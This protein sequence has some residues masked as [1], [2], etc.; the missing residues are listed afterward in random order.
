MTIQAWGANRVW[1]LANMRECRAFERALRAP[2]VAQEEKLRGYLRRNAG[3]A[4]AREHGLTERTTL[5][6][7]RGRV[8]VRS[9]AEL[10]GYVDRIG[11]GEAGVLT[12]ERVEMFTP[13]S[14]ST[15]GAGSVKLIPRTASLRGE[16][17]AALAPWVNGMFAERPGV[18][19]GPAYWSVSPV[20]PAEKRL[21]GV[22]PVGF[23][24][25]DEY[26]SWVGRKIARAVKAIPGGTEGGGGVARMRSAA[27]WRYA[28]L[29]MLLRTRSLAM[30]S[31]W[32][33]S[34]LEL[35]LE[36]MPGWWERLCADVAAGSATLPEESGVDRALAPRARG[37]AARAAELRG[38]G[39]RDV[40]G[41]WPGLEL[42]SC[43]ADGAAA[44]H[45]RAL[46]D[47]LGGVAVV[48]KGLLATEA[49]V[50]IPW[51]GMHPVAVRS[52]FVEL[53]DE[54][55]C[56]RSLHEARPGEAYVPVV[57]TGGGLWR[58]RLGDR[59]VVD[60]FVERT[61]SLRFVGRVDSVSDLRGEKLSDAFV[62]ASLAECEVKLGVRARFS[63]LGGDADG[64][65][66]IWFVDAGDGGAALE[67]AEALDE[68]LAANPH[69]AY[70][71]RLGQLRAPVVVRVDAGAA[72]DLL[73]RVERAG[74][75]GGVKP[76]SLCSGEVA[77]ALMACTERAR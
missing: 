48:G 3:T 50:S 15:G 10:A 64:A 58:Y 38:C 36:A 54:R 68:R 9:Y 5:E 46:G 19:V 53:E 59:V 33:P 6:E 30:V 62:S 24:D 45:A 8:P 72:R 1:Q 43:W 52:H 4:F 76:V 28:T 73:A 63:V 66:Y 40:R 25:D 49:F 35:L 69:Y 26:L 23:G 2:A 14:G 20:G 29:L 75:S 60:G 13:T 17:A 32:H 47:R 51:K 18:R 11:A 21:H 42:V 74:L 71:R 37:D 44:A 41:V 27:N 12:A 70:A 61:P 39:P 34:F 77:R 7:F 57:T 22:V 31:V 67:S 16:F 65:G 56:V 55:G